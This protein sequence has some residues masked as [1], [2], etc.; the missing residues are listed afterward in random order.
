MGSSVNF[1]VGRG[2]SSTT[3]SVADLI[4]GLALPNIGSLGADI[5]A[6]SDLPA[7][8]L[9]KEATTSN[10]ASVRD[11][12]GTYRTS[13][14]NPPPR[15]TAAWNETPERTA[16]DDDSQV[17]SGTTV[18]QPPKR[19][20]SQLEAVRMLMDECADGVAA[21]HRHQNQCTAL[22]AVLIDRFQAAGR[23]EATILTLG[24]WQHQPH[25]A[26]ICAE[27][28]GLLNIPE[29]IADRLMD[30]ASTL[31]HDVPRTLAALADGWL[32]WDH[33]AI[34]A[35]EATLLRHAGLPAE[36]IESFEQALLEK[37]VDSTL[38]SFREKARRLRERRYPESIPVRTRRSFASRSLRVSR[39]QD[40]MSWLSLY[41][42]APTAEGIWDQ[43]TLTAQATQ[44]PHED[45]TLTQL[46]ADVAA[47]LLLNQ[48]MAQNHLYSPV[49]SDST[50]GSITS[51]T[52]P[53]PASAVNQGG[54]GDTGP[55]AVGPE[56]P[57][58]VLSPPDMAESSPTGAATL[59]P[60]QSTSTN[61]SGNTV[62]ERLMGNSVARR[63][64]TNSDL[65][66]ARNNPENLYQGPEPL[67]S[68]DGPIPDPDQGW[69]R[70]SAEDI[71]VFE[72][73]NYRDPN[74]K[75][76][77]IRNNPDWLPAAN[78]P[79]LSPAPSSVGRNVPEGSSTDAVWPPMPQVT[80][81]VLI[82]V[83]SMLGATNEPAWMEGSG[84]ISMEVAQ[85]LMSESS[86]FY[87]VL[88]DPLTNKPL[89]CSPQRYRVTKAMRTM[90]RIRDEYC[91]FPGCTAKACTSDIDHI[92]KFESGGPTI[93][94]NLQSL[95][96][97]HH[98]MKHFK[99]DRT[100]NGQYRTDQSPERSAVRL[101]GWTP[102]MTDNGVAWTSPSG[103]HYLPKSNDSQ[104][105]V[106]TKWLRKF[107]DNSLRIQYL[108]EDLYCGDSNEGVYAENCQ[109][110]QW[111]DD[112]IPEPPA[113]T[114]PNDE[115]NEIL[116]QIAIENYLLK[117]ASGEPST[118]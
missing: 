66:R 40:G 88:V 83:L 43:C 114:F 7:L 3:S 51:S 74:Y 17:A 106:Y 68:H 58:T 67:P 37:A 104:A 39:G 99:D 70:L 80:P 21:L 98:Q 22:A 26:G 47:A 27:I 115:D 73:P 116:T 109:E 87:R 10:R 60:G 36:T 53:V 34:I 1:P 57:G 93:F 46:R 20:Q 69:Y 8:P 75:D 100:R 97:R 9:P 15:T 103:R 64:A 112:I 50:A 16:G 13:S 11:G 79:V 18:E 102:V 6:M 91:Q 14:P 24:S 71:P 111:D 92:Q 33:A 62:S 30:L 95:C 5:A 84:P 78:P 72:D 44:G 19:A 52:S 61:C 32:D 35:D 118:G 90:L 38:P 86:S 55:T 89:D 23:L 81:V 101:R 77:D 45:R 48:S 113:G 117:H 108:T 31:V 2:N 4:A 49:S 25:M 65:A 12:S 56:H 59:L 42:P 85:H 82:P 94:D 29:N 107:I 96:K 63:I 28:A 54:A 76:P 105:P 110:E 41:L